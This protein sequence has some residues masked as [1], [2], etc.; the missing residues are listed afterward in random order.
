MSI[1]DQ[2]DQRPC[3]CI[4]RTHARLC[5]CCVR[6]RW[7]REGKYFAACVRWYARICVNMGAIY[8]GMC[9]HNMS[10]NACEYIR[11]QEREREQCDKRDETVVGALW[12]YFYGQALC[13][14]REMDVNL[15][16][17]PGHVSLESTK[18]MRVMLSG[19]NGLRI[20]RIYNVD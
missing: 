4:T 19:S 9:G 14:G 20:Q 11:R 1:T 17:I 5:G 8:V 12:E 18:P 15:L 6:D 13:E 16:C 3:S 2:S 7:L 10:T